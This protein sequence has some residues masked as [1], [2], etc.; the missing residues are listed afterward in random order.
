MTSI[1][2]K[3]RTFFDYKSVIKDSV[4]NILQH[5]LVAF[6]LTGMVLLENKYNSINIC[7]WS[8]GKSCSSTITA[9]I[10]NTLLVK[11]LLISIMSR[12]SANIFLI[13]L[14]YSF[15]QVYP[16]FSLV[17]SCAGG[18]VLHENTAQVSLQKF[19]VQ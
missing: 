17:Y 11:I 6:M 10:F 15:R 1:K 2:I 5:V 3:C 9:F 18:W 7:S 19:S 16:I 12:A 8:R 14:A 13:L 4:P